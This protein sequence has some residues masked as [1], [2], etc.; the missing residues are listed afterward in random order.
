MNLHGS[1]FSIGQPLQAMGRWLHPYRHK[2]T[3]K[4]RDKLVRVEW[5]KRAEAAL[6]ARTQPLI[7]EMQLYFSCVVQK[8]V[9]FHDYFEHDT[10]PLNDKIQLAFRPVEAS[11][12]DPEE[13]ANNHPVKQEFF[14]FGARQMLPS[15]IQIDYKENSW[16]GMFSI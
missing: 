16:E 12:C 10:V 1:Y 3:V 8:R 14:S 7:M 4:L 2:T 15:L 6:K 5:T 11:S 9:L 13:F